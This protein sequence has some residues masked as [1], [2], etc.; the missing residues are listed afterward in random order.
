MAENL[1]Y[2]TDG[3][4]SS[5]TPN[6]NKICETIC[7]ICRKISLWPNAKQ[8]LSVLLKSKVTN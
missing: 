1:N 2:P 5:S 3:S 7:G 6:L 8:A 4:H